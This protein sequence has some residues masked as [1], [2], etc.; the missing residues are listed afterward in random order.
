VAQGQLVLPKGGYSVKLLQRDGTSLGNIGEINFVSPTVSTQTGTL[1][2]RAALA[3]P[4]GTI[5]SGLFVR[6]LLEG[7]ERPNALTVPQ[8]AVLEGPKG[9][10]VMVAAK[11][12]EGALVA[13]PRPIEVGEWVNGKDDEKLWV[14]RSG[15]QAGDQV[16]VEGLMKLHPGAPI[17]L[18]KAAGAADSKPVATTGSSS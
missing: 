11:N 8:R 10:L 15:L 2:M 1:E 4:G 7:A 3:N 6:V 9:K 16:I 14:V 17:S 18:G 13:E 5:K 12:K